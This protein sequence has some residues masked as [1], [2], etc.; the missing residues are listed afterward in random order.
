MTSEAPSSKPRVGCSDK[1]SA[2]GRPAAL[3]FTVLLCVFVFKYHHEFM[4]TRRATPLA[5]GPFSHFVIDAKFPNIPT[6]TAAKVHVGD[7][8]KFRGW[9]VATV[10]EKS[11]G[12]VLGSDVR[13]LRLRLRSPN[14]LRYYLDASSGAQVVFQTNSYLLD[15]TIE[16]VS[17]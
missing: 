15:G 2:P 6:D 9:T 11:L 7:Q 4:Q 1:T 16:Q 12:E 14:W 13:E 8:T 17:P 5:G 3:V 10:V